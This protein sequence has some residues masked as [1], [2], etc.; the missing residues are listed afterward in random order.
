MEQPRRS[1]Y[2]RNAKRTVKAGLFE[3]VRRPGALHLYR[4]QLGQLNDQNGSV[5]AV[6]FLVCT[7]LHADLYLFSFDKSAV[8]LQ[9]GEQNPATINEFTEAQKLISTSKGYS[10]RL[11]ENFPKD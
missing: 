2:I 11:E 6:L 10:S 9:I 3:T 5:F 7:V 4:R 1:L 8:F